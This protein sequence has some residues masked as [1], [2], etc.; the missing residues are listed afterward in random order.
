MSVRLKVLH[1]AIKK[2]G[3]WQLTVPI[4]KS[5]FVIGQATDCNMRCYGRAISDYHCEISVSDFGVFVRDLRSE[6]GTF[7]NGEKLTSTQRFVNGDQY[8]AK[9][10]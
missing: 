6:S 7:I 9:C 1:G 2:R 3:E 8:A 10:H 4:K 5:P